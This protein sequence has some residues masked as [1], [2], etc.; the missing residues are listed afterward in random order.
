MSDDYSPIHED[1]AA[2]SNHQDFKGHAEN[3]AA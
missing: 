3:N 2:G 1:E